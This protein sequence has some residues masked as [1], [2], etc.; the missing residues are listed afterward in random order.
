VFLASEQTVS[1]KASAFRRADGTFESRP[2]EDMAPFLP[3]EEIHE[4]MNLFS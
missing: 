1:P 2:L 3:R 4:N